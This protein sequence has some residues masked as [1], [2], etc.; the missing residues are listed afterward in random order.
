MEE[1][2]FN[3]NNLG[4]RTFWFC[5]GILIN[6]VGIAFITK[7]GMGTSQISSVPYVLSFQFPQL[8]F[9]MCTFLINFVLVAVQIPGNVVNFSNEHF[10]FLEHVRGLAEA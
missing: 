1:T 8:S 2:G 6:S 4:R 10:G 5:L 3:T 7:A 9:A